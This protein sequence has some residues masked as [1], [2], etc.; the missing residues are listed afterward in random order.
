MKLT[1]WRVALRIARRDALRA[2]GRSALIVG[3]IA[4]PVLGVA[5]AD[6][7]YRS[8]Q[9]TPQERIERSLG[10][11]DALVGALSPGRTV[12]QA[13]NAD[14]GTTVLADPEGQKPTPEQV[15]GAATD[16]TALVAGL[17]PPGSTLASAR[18]GPEASASSRSGLLLTS[19]AEADLGDPLW[20]GR[21]T[22]SRAV[23]CTPLTRRP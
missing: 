9:L 12:A 15:K 11:S 4:L 16:P 1:S 2:K 23:P 13:P 20:R 5:G 3:M 19:T 21:S 7:A 22:W 17:L 14:D 10:T 18:P 8:A 6:V